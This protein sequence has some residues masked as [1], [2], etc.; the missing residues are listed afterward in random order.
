[1]NDIPTVTES[2]TDFPPPIVFVNERC[3]HRRLKGFP[4]EKCVSTCPHKAL[5]LHNGHISID[6]GSC[7][8]CF[9]CCAACP[10]EALTPSGLQLK[11]FDHLLK[12]DQSEVIFSCSQHTFTHRQQSDIPCLGIFSWELLLAIGLSNISVIY[13]AISECGTCKNSNVLDSLRHKIQRIKVIEPESISK[14]FRFYSNP[15][16]FAKDKDGDRRQFL[17]TL[18]HG[19]LSLATSRFKAPINQHSAIV[20]S[21]R[22]IPTKTR[23]LSEAVNSLKTTFQ[24]PT[25]A[26]FFYQLEVKESCTLCPLC[27]GICPT[28]AVK[29]IKTE[30]HKNITFNPSICSGCGLCVSFCKQDALTITAPT[31]R[32][33]E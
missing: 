7:T 8:A 24:P 6:N 20:K 22:H 32:L 23:L 1:M 29:V 5:F 16:V 21:T 11:L 13:F 25:T 10:S 2:I 15:R 28:G 17:S 33:K 4:C 26:H 9:L 31:Y 19:L 18:A 27:T 14:K 30:N 12:S 3:L